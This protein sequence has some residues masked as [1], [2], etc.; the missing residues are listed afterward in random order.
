MPIQHPLPTESTVKRLYAH[1]FRCAYYGC[2]R[3][4]YKVDDLSGDRILNSRICHIH[5][6]KE[7]GPRWNTSQSAEENRSDKN[8]VLMCVEHAS[9][10][11]NPDTVKHY[12]PK[13][14]AEWKAEQLREFDQIRQGWVLSSEMAAEALQTPKADIFIRDSTLN[15]GGEGGRAPGAGGAGG[16]AIGTNARGGDGGSGGDVFNGLFDIENLE[17]EG[18]NR[19]MSLEIGKGGSPATLPGQHSEHGGDTNIAFHIPDGTLAK[20]TLR[21]GQGARSPASYLPPGVREL[22]QHDLNNGFRVTCLMPANY[23]EIRDNLLFIVGGSW[24]RIQMETPCSEAVFQVVLSASWRNQ[25]QTAVGM[26]VS[27][28]NPVGEEVSC[29]AFFIT[30]NKN[31]INAIWNTTIGARFDVEGEW[32]LVAHSGK[33][34]LSKAYIQV[35]FRT[36]G[37]K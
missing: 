29:K 36:T 17:K 25:M 23:A 24:S 19:K 4:L 9:T 7:G 26:Y 13:L 14:L 8:L 37:S 16:G 35:S 31:D 30:A 1:A 15:L 21:G 22:E 12:S 20:F 6:R 34:L 11:D 18:F 27:L 5:A 3:P 28:L 2:Q 10:I 32:Q 33:I